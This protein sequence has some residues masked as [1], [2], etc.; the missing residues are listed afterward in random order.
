MT[1]ALENLVSVLAGSN[2]TH[3]SRLL[4]WGDVA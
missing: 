2:R 1:N 3:H 4:S